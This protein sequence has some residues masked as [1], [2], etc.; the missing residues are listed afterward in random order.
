MFST[1]LSLYFVLASAL[2]L[3]SVKSAPITGIARD[4]KSDL[5]LLNRLHNNVPSPRVRPNNNNVDLPLGDF[6]AALLFL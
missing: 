6:N 4:V 5:V 1:F 2:T 3:T